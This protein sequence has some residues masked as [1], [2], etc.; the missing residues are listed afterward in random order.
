MQRRATSF[1]PPND[2][3]ELF[4]L[5]IKM[6]SGLAR[7]F[8]KKRKI[9]H[10]FP[11]H[12]KKQRK[13]VSFRSKMVRLN[14][15]VMIINLSRARWSVLHPRLFRHQSPTFNKKWEIEITELTRIPPLKWPN[16]TESNVVIVLISAYNKWTMGL[17]RF[18]IDKP[19]QKKEKKV[20]T[21]KSSSFLRN[22]CIH[23]LWR[24][25]SDDFLHCRNACSQNFGAG[26]S[27]IYDGLLLYRKMWMRNLTRG[28]MVRIVF[29]QSYKY[30]KSIR[31]KIKIN[32]FFP[33][34]LTLISGN[35]T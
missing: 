28:E 20:A 7:G 22:Y 19:L 32:V 34:K 10:L 13:G 14:L 9:L 15:E 29:W 30:R 25:F 17:K 2:T 27:Y 12:Q 21:I 26:P 35:L 3:S 31:K 16:H 4:H 18:S 6:I 5:N 1:P 24:R 33:H 23:G 11:E 8:L